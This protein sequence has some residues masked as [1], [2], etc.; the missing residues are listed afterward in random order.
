MFFYLIGAAAL[1]FSLSLDAFTA[2]FAYGCKKI[3]IPPLSAI[4]ITFICT[5]TVGLSFLAGS[6]LAQFIPA[7]VAVGLSFTILLIIGIARLLD[8]ITKTIIRKH[9]G[10][11][12]EIKL[13]L[14]NFKFILRLYADPE[15]ADVDE[16]KSISSKEAAVLAISLSLDGFAVGF[17]AAMLDFNAWAVIA[18][19]LLANGLALWLGG[20]FGNKAA[21]SLRFNISWL[22]GVILICLAFIQLI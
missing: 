7:W 5:A 12:K 8:S 14:F 11:N 9:A 22:A 19:S 18:F 2:A 3:R 13:S 21:K 1:A 16:S 10:I 20:M 4:I 17:G 6:G 15:T